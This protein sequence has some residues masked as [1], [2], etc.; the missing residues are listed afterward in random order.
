MMERDKHW[1]LQKADPIE[2]IR[3]L[4]L[5]IDEGTIL[6]FEG[7]EPDRAI[8][9]FFEKYKPDLKLKP[10]HDT[11]DGTQLSFVKWS[12]EF[13][14]DFSELLSKREISE[15]CYHFKGFKNGLL[16][17]WYHDA[18]CKCDDP[19]I[20]TYISENKIKK[21]TEKINASYKLEESAWYDWGSSFNEI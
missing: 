17:F 8:K 13:Q 15:V 16:M 9:K 7:L 6:S 18:D 1:K 12:K 5:L 10:W 3:H 4:E 20:S 11:S 2:F 21:F 14:S 19:V